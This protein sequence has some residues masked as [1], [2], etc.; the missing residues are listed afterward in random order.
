MTKMRSSISDHCRCLQTQELSLS[1]WPGPAHSGDLGCLPWTSLSSSLPPPGSP[2]SLETLLGS[3]GRE[4]SPPS[5]R[6]LSQCWDA[7]QRNEGH[8]IGTSL[9][10][11][12]KRNLDVGPFS[13]DTHIHV[14]CIAE[15]TMTSNE[16]AVSYMHELSV[17]S[18]QHWIPVIIGAG[19]TPH[20]GPLPPLLCGASCVC[21]CKC[22]CPGLFNLAGLSSGPAEDWL[23][24]L[25]AT[26]ME[27]WFFSP[28]H[29]GYSCPAGVRA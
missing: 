3:G 26:S 27:L 19:Q 8:L 23:H 6:P 1:C 18:L 28:H 9:S 11:E 10:M 14:C 12:L 5:H 24:S 17:L 22:P 16:L 25:G 15:T 20:T 21:L 13:D 4:D 2:V 29:T 7:Y